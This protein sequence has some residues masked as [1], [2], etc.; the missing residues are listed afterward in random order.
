MKA[1]SDDGE[2]SRINGLLIVRLLVLE[3]GPEDKDSTG[4]MN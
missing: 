1:R 2:G 3:H 4:T